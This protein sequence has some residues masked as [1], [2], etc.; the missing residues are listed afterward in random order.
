MDTIKIYKTLYLD[1]TAP[2]DRMVVLA[3]DITSKD[4]EAAIK[5]VQDRILM[6]IDTTKIDTVS[7]TTYIKVNIEQITQIQSGIH[8][9]Y[10]DANFLI[11]WKKNH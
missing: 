8:D 6:H 3:T 1:E 9:A 2:C 4:Q 10:G 5:S 11:W 7:D